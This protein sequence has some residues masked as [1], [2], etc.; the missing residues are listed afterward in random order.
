MAFSMT[1]FG[2]AH[3]TFDQIDV[4]IE[5]RSVNNRFQEIFIRLP[6][7]HLMY[8]FDIRDQVS[9]NTRR[10]KIN[11]NIQVATIN[12]STEPIQINK[13]RVKEYYESLNEINSLLKFSKPVE[14]SDILKFEDI[15]NMDDLSKKDEQTKK[16]ILE[17]TKEA[18]NDFNEM[19]KLEGIELQ[20]DLIMRNDNLDNYLKNVVKLNSNI[21]RKE[22]EKLCD[23]LKDNIF[24][25]EVDKDRLELELAILADRS[26]IT[27]ECV[28]M[29]KPY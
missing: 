22:F 2:K 11:V 10:G 6:K 18:L 27:E 19:R 21:S 15:F 13:D 14:L 23:R 12:G 7:T 29:G 24:N 3:K 25:K 8:E 1:G 9:K 28:R 17:V 20:K 5:I 16:Y 4:S 26:D